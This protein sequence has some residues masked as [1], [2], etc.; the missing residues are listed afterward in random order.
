[1]VRHTGID[2]FLKDQSYRGYLNADAHNVYDHLFADG[3][4]VEVGCWAHCRRHFY[5]ARQSDPA[6]SHL[7]LAR[8][9]QLNEVEKEAKAIIARD[10]LA[11]V[12]ADALRRQLRQEQASAVVTALGH[13]LKQEQP[14]VLPKSPIGQA[15]AYARRHWQA[16]T[17]Y[18]DDGFLDID[19]NAAER[20]LRHIALGRKN[21]LFAGSAAGARTAATLF[22]VTST[23]HRHGVDAFAYV[24]DLLTRLAHDPRPAC[25]V[26]RDWLPDHWQPPAA[27]PGDA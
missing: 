8:I 19:N 11:G 7:V 2:A 20:T 26:L 27:S 25:E 16:L 9:R 22:S 10:E 17:R 24:R 23:C 21:W 14:A 12:E 4:I 18:L 13:W 6:R 3:A 1:L 15:I 5:E